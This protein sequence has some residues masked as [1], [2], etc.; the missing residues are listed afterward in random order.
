MAKKDVGTRF[1]F[2]NLEKALAKAQKMFEAD[3]QGRPMAVPTAYDVWGYSAKSSGGHQTV[4][5]L[6]AYGLLD[7][8]G[9]LEE[10]KLFL[11]EDAKRYFLDE[12]EAEKTK[13]LTKF[14]LEPKLINALWEDWGGSPPADS[15]ARSHL[16]LD[17]KL[18]EQ[19]ARSLLGIYKDNLDFADLKGGAIVKKE[20]NADI[21]V[22][23]SADEGI[24]P[25]KVGDII[26]WTSG[27]VDQFET[28]KRVEVVHASGEW[29]WVENVKQGIPMTEATVL[30]RSAG[31]GNAPP[32]RPDLEPK[33]QQQED[34]AAAPVG[35]PRVTLDGDTMKISATVKMDELS[36]F[37]QQID[38][39]E[40][41]YK[42]G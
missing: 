15:I 7:D 22:D 14:A 5:A 30:E 11:T 3:S 19:S 26:Q 37:R 9:A 23:D 18:N 2:I 4:G 31:S 40:A 38:A 34:T 33:R 20:P 36:K 41:F 13:L 10:R 25:A 27:G 28:G 42:A 6:K 21:P 1:P 12:R 32:P 24:E 39:L 17:R 35:K 8:E 29:L 16:K